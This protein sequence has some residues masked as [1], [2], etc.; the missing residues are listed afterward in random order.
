MKLNRSMV[1][2]LYAM[3]ALMMV[4]PLGET[5]LSV[6]PLRLGEPA[7]R[8]GAAGLF[9]RALMTPMLGLVLFAVLGFLLHHRRAV[10]IAAVLALLGAAVLAV[11]EVLFILDALQMRARVREEARLAFDLASLLAFFKIG[12]SCAITTVLGVGAWKTARATAGHTRSARTDPAAA[13]PMGRLSRS[14]PEP[15]VDVAEAEPEPLPD[16]E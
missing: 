11:A 1:F 8:F 5:L 3:T 14:R 13:L 12:L 4:M 10:Q 7:W 9:S 2:V 16:E 15:A 6:S